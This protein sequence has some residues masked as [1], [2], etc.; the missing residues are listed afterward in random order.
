MIIFSKR[1]ILKSLLFYI[2]YKNEYNRYKYRSR[3]NSATL[4]NTALYISINSLFYSTNEY[5]VY[6]THESIFLSTPD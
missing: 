3:Q 4:I 5:L 1:Y 6:S 2:H